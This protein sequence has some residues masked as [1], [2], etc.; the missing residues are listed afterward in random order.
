VQRGDANFDCIL[1]YDISPWGRFQDVDESA[2]YECVC[3][4]AGINI[5]YCADEFENDGSLA[6]VVLKN[7]RRV[8][9][10]DYSRQLSKKVFLG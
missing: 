6:S 7:I 10:A 2:Y 3:R 9:A 5:H 1:V 8:A 4:R